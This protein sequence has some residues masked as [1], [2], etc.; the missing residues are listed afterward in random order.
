MA[1][2]LKREERAYHPLVRQMNRLFGDF[3]GETPS[4]MTGMREFTPSIDVSETESDILVKAEVPGV[5]PEEIDISITD[6]SVFIKGEKKEESE[7]REEN[8]YHFERKYGSFSREISLP[9]NV[10]KD[11]ASAE[12]RDGVLTVKLPKQEKEKA[13]AIKVQSR[14]E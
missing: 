2:I 10:K 7:T 12:T 11:E 8:Y 9:A 6:D 1:N 4:A 13:R 5:D 14:K 3:F